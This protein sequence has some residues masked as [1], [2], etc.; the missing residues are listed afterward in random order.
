[1]NISI[2]KIEFNKIYITNCMNDK[3]DLILVEQIFKLKKSF[4]RRG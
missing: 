3:K 1:M 2:K 4:V